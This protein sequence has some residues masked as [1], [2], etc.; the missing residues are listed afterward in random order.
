MIL[1]LFQ[2]SREILACAKRNGPLKGKPPFLG[3]GHRK[4]A[5]ELLHAPLL[6]LSLLLYSALSARILRLSSG[7]P[8]ERVNPP[9]KAWGNVLPNQ[10]KGCGGF[11]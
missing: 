11:P 2:W 5:R 10:G 6:R 3:P 4:H 8:T 9:T 1:Q 7:H